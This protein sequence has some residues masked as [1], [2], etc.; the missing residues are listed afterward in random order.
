[1]HRHSK[2]SYSSSEVIAYGSPHSTLC[3]GEDTVSQSRQGAR[4]ASHG[5]YRWKTQ[6]KHA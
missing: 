6:L 3:F 4:E 5:R 2:G 1:M